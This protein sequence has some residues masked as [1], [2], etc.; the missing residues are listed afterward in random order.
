MALSVL[1]LILT[2]IFFCYPNIETARIN[3]EEAKRISEKNLVLAAKLDA[4]SLLEEKDLEE[5]YKIAVFGLLADKNPDK[6]FGVFDAILT[7][8]DTKEISAGKLEFIPGEMKNKKVSVGKTGIF[9][10]NFDMPLKGKKDQVFNF[11]KYVETGYPLMTIREVSGEIKDPIDIKI[12]FSLHAFPDSTNMPPLETP[13]DPFS[14]S[15]NLLSEKINT[16][17]AMSTPS[18]AMPPLQ[19]F[20]RTDLFE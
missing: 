3:F 7:K 13:L 15:E 9:D 10:L 4:L 19:K 12:N 1:T 16:A 18:A 6:V 5:K 17:I 20:N 8:D 2:A 14:S 11:I